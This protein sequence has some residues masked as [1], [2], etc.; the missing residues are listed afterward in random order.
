MQAHGVALPS[1][2]ALLHSS[3]APASLSSVFC[4]GVSGPPPLPWLLGVRAGG[5]PG[6]VPKAAASCSSYSASSCPSVGCAA[7]EWYQQLW[8]RDQAQS[9]SL[10]QGPQ[11]EPLHPLRGSEASKAQREDLQPLG[12]PVPPASHTSNPGVGTH[13]VSSGICD[14]GP[15]S[16]SVLT[17]HFFAHTFQIL[18]PSVGHTLPRSTASR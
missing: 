8:S 11:G 18:V 15:G 2:P 16:T 4:L 9:C 6:A 12:T 14:T 13:F 10:A 3:A 1:Q 5:P 7:P 17:Y